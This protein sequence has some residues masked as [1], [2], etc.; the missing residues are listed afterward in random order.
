MLSP[1]SRVKLGG[2]Q[3]QRSSIDISSG[4]T[5]RVSSGSTGALHVDGRS[6]LKRTQVGP[7]MAAILD[8]LD[9]L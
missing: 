7:E 4:Q 6:R 1:V 2:R 5:L 8:L 9:L 3:A